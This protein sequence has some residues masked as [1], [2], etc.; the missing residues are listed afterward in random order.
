M[1]TP[2][3]I[4]YIYILYIHITNNVIWMCLK[5]GYM[6]NPNSRVSGEKVERSVDLGLLLSGWPPVHRRNWGNCDM[7][8]SVL[9]SR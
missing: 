6:Y 7:T 1:E 5:I 4:L 2:I 9:M 8:L 3:Y